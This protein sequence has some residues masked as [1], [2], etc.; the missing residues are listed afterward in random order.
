MG[1]VCPFLTRALADSILVRPKDGNS[2]LARGEGIAEG[3]L[4]GSPS[5]PLIYGGREPEAF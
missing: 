2:V 1:Q 4:T 3:A 5:N